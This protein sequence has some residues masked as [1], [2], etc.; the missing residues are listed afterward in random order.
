MINK[1][2][3]IKTSQLI[4][5]KSKVTSKVM[6]PNLMIILASSSPCHIV[7]WFIKLQNRELINAFD[8]NNNNNNNTVIDRPSS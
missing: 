8:L 1:S 7:I 5:F 2:F 6:E 4:N 3:S